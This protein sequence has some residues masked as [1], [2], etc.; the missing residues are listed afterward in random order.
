MKCTKCGVEVSTSAKF[1]A[2]CG[3]PIH[4][5]ESKV[6]AKTE[7]EKPKPSRSLGIW[8]VIVGVA[9]IGTY[10]SMFIPAFV[11]QKPS[12]NPPVG[13]YV[14]VWTSLFFYLGWKQKGGKGWQGALIGAGIGVLVY[15]GAIMVAVS[16]QTTADAKNGAEQIVDMLEEF[17]KESQKVNPDGTPAPIAKTFA[18]SADATGSMAIMQQFIADIVNRAAEMN[19]DYLREL[20]SIG[21]NNFLDEDRLLS[22]PTFKKSWHMVTE[23][24]LIVDKYEMRGLE[25]MKDSRNNIQFLSL[26]DSEKKAIEDGFNR[27]FE[28]NAENRERMW[29]LERLTIDEMEKVIYL[30]AEDSQSWEIE[31]GQFLF[32]SDQKIDRFNE[33]ITNMEKFYAEQIELQ[34]MIIQGQRERLEELF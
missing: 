13:L 6:A 32:E 24:R 16:N 25:I 18:P 3:I 20:D 7:S 4:S 27:G 28:K 30:L 21:W 11:G 5:A 14:M 1:C 23:A 2:N 33:H 34:D 10:A 29:V 22:D 19:N 15:T 12:T 9:L 26:S 31:D 17:Y 8:I